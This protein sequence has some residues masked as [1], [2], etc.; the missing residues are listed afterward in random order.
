MISGLNK[1]AKIIF[2]GGEPIIRK[3][4]FDILEYANQYLKTV[5]LTNGWFVNEK[6]AKNF[7]ETDHVQVSLDG[8]ENTNDK[9]TGIFACRSEYRPNPIAITTCEILD[10]NKAKGIVNIK[11]IDAY[12]GTEIIDL[13]AYFPVCDRVKNA[14]IPDWLSFWPEWMPDEGIGLWEDE[15]DKEL[16]QLIKENLKK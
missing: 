14:K 13:K 10:V 3:D 16:D 4:F 5:V 15:D 11:N 8:L 6:N 1:I 12:D 2:N 9:L 7:K